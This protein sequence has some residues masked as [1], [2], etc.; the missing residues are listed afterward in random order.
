LSEIH[1]ALIDWGVWGKTAGSKKGK[2]FYLLV[3]T[4]F[5]EKDFLMF[6]RQLMGKIYK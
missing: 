2:T 4:C 1:G 5:I 3:E 6:V